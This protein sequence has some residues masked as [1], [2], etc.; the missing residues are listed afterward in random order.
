M[1]SYCSRILGREGA[2]KYE[3]SNHI[4]LFWKETDGMYSANQ[5]QAQEGNIISDSVGDGA[6]LKVARRNI[7]TLG[8]IHGHC[9]VLNGA[10]ILKNLR[11]DMQLTDAIYDICRGD[12]EASASKREGEDG[13][14]IGG[15]A[16]AATKLEEKYRNVSALNVK[17]IKSLLFSVYNIIMSAYKLINPD[18]VAC[19]MADMEK[20][21][22]KYERL[23]LQ[24]S[25]DAENIN[26]A[27]IPV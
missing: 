17:D 5:A 27:K 1:R 22:R 16:A 25:Q 10:E 6:A 14:I 7:N 23:P 13:N 20:D 21:I 19:L 11:D 24:T 26:I 15:A 18:Y 4:E 9:G 8:N 3:G 2:W 12:T